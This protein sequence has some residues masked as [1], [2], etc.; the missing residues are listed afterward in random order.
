M[1]AISLD[2]D[3]TVAMLNVA[4]AVLFAAMSYPLLVGMVPRNKHFGFRTSKSMASD[5]AWNQ[6]NRL[7]GRCVLVGA[8]LI[9]A[10]NAAYLLTGL[11]LPSGASA[12]L[13]MYSAPVGLLGSG[14]AA[15]LLHQR[16]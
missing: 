11:P 14:L 5:E 13:V 6:A 10:L 8:G 4:M 9:A 7:A 15:W 16:D 1:E 12:Q 2:T 3:R